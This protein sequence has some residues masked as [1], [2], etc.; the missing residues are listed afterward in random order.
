M[1]D[2]SIN[3]IEIAINLAGGLAIFLFGMTQMSDAL[4]L[5]AGD[6]LRDLL[7]Q[8][9]S[10]RILSVISGTFTTALTQSSSVTTVLL[11]GFV[12]AGLMTL[13]QSIGVIMGANVGSTLTAQIIAFKVT[14]YALLLTALGFAFASFLKRDHWRQWGYALMGLGLIFLGMNIMSQATHPLRSYEPFIEL[15]KQMDIPLYGILVGA[16]FTA[17]IQSSAATTGL[18]IIMAS[19]GVISLEAGIAMAFGANIGTCATA[20]LASLGKPRESMQVAVAH[21]L[22]NLLGVLIWLPFISLFAEFTRHVSPV[23][24]GSSISEK[25]IFETPRQIA[26]AHSIFNIVNTIFFICFT[27]Q[28]A[29][30]IEWLLPIK[31]KHHEISQNLHPMYFDSPATALEKVAD[32]ISAMGES[33]DRIVQEI[34]GVFTASQEELEKMKNSLTDLNVVYEKILSFLRQLGLSRLSPRQSTRQQFLI[35]VANE[36]NQISDILEVNIY[37]LAKEHKQLKLTPSIE[38]VRLIDE[39]GSTVHGAFILALTALKTNDN[40][41]AKQVLLFKKNVKKLTEKAISHITKR[42]HSDDPGRIEL[43]RIENDLCYQI[44]RFYTHI[45][46]IA[47]LVNTEGELEPQLF[48]ASELEGEA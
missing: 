43:F 33:I 2:Q 5:V 29:R 7:A 4:K 23:Y 3:F 44:Q 18:L 22:F 16:V 30:F 6:K 26:N 20:L 27:S 31:S 34:S 25:L 13:Q 28:L 15:M 32:E 9:T 37:T 11:V 8:M 36:L 46:R 17:I 47:K 38:S 39:L 21:I 41:P 19:Q 48:E 12:S 10:N 24:I 42:L 1:A 14:E 35:S 40:Y 45:R